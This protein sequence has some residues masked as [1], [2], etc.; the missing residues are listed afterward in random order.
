MAGHGIAGQVMATFGPAQMLKDH[1][2]A[3]LLAYRFAL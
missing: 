1:I 3:R 2:V